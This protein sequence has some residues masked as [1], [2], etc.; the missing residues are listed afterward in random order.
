[1]A[2]RRKHAPGTT[3]QGVRDLG[4]TPIRGSKIEPYCWHVWDLV[5]DTYYLCYPGE[6]ENSYERCLKCGATRGR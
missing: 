5:S 6:R 2:R 4:S 3:R 1:M